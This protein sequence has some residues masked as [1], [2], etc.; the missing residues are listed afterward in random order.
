MSTLL[1]YLDDQAGSAQAM[2]HAAA[3][4]S[5]PVAS[6]RFPDGELRLTLP[7]DA[8]HAPERLAIYRS[9]HQPNDKLIE[10]LLM[11]G[12][13]RDWG[14]R[15]IILVAPYLAYMRQDIS[16]HPGEV[17][18]QRVL[19]RLLAQCLDGV[20][21]VDPHLHRVATLAEAVPVPQAI[22]L[23][24]APLLAAHVGRMLRQMPGASAQPVLIGPDGES[25]PWIQSA[26]AVL[27]CPFGVCS[28][29]RHGDREVVVSLPK[30][31]VQGRAVVLLDDIASSG[32]TLA[33]AARGLIQRG[34]RSVDV[35]V[36]HA[37]FAPGAEFLVR[38]AGVRHIW[39]TDAVA[40]DTNAV[41]LAGLLAPA[42]LDLIARA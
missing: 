30:V 5:A 11:A 37:L 33:E 9:L 26:A 18:S 16:F 2:A 36:T 22:A 28:K 32:H 7:F 6:H 38:D 41:S 34:A 31:D 20:I 14:V 8:G 3:L 24:A 15:Q 29:V 13:A 10:I 42:C 4:P 1:L 17:V 12:Q 35:A 23:S 27:G 21:T 25:A 39:S 19:G 40:H